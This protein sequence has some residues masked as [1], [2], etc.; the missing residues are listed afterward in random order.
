MVVSKVTIY[1][2]FPITKRFIDANLDDVSDWIVKE[3]SADGDENNNSYEIVNK[4][5]SRRG[6]KDPLVVDKL[7]KCCHNPA[8]GVDTPLFMVGLPLKS[9]YRVKVKCADCGV[10]TVCDKCLGT[11]ENGF[12]DLVRIS[13]E[14]VSLPEDD[15]CA[16]CNHHQRR[17]ALGSKVCQVCHYDL[18]NGHKYKPSDLKSEFPVTTKNEQCG[19]YLV[20]DDCLSCT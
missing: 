9:Y 7:D 1:Y 3:D 12:Y 14:L 4:C 15:I 6:C 8:P 2:G 20:A 11:T 10:H 16:N 19:Y 5:V 18:S 17:D 13:K